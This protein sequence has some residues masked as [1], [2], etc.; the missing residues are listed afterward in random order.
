MMDKEIKAILEGPQLHMMSR[1]GVTGEVVA[2]AKVTN[3]A[4][5]TVVIDPIIETS[6]DTPQAMLMMSSLQMPCNL[7]G[8]A[9]S[10]AVYELALMFTNL[11]QQL[12]KASFAM[13]EEGR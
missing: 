5:I 1:K 3:E 9:T 12:R 11:S 6:A 13:K 10:D 7:K 4:T 8:M 2:F